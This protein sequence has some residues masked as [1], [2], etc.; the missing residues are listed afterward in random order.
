MDPSPIPLSYQP[1]PPQSQRFSLGVLGLIA[2]LIAVALA[3]AGFLI[4][5]L[6]PDVQSQTLWIGLNNGLHLFS[7]LSGILAALTTPLALYRNPKR[8]EVIAFTL[9][10]IYWTSFALSR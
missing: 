1:R 8:R 4:D 5:V 10:V 9:T 7:F 3:A 6:P 2:S